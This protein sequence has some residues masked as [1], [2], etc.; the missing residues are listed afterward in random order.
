[1]DRAS[2]TAARRLNAGGAQG[3]GDQCDDALN[4]PIE[5]LS[6]KCKAERE[7]AQST[8]G[9]ATDGLATGSTNPV[10]DSSGV[11]PEETNDNNDPPAK[12]K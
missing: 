10:P 8:P 3:N 7:N 5:Q 4:V 9:T 1:M 12:A 2:T 6:D 11:I